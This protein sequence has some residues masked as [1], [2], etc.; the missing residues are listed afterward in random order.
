ME[1]VNQL[2]RHCFTLS[3]Q[4]KVM[5]SKYVKDA[6]H[7]IIDQ[8]DADDIINAATTQGIYDLTLGLLDKERRMMVAGKAHEASA[9]TYREAREGSMEAHNFLSAT[10]ITSIHMRNEKKRDASLAATAKSL[11]KS[12]LSIGATMLKV[13]EDKMKESKEE[14]Y[15][16][17]KQIESNQERVTID[18]IRMLI[19]NANKAMLLETREMDEGMAGNNLNK[20]E[21]SKS[22]ENEFEE[23]E[24]KMRRAGAAL[25]TRMEEV[26]IDLTDTESEEDSHNTPDPLTND[27]EG[28]DYKADNSDAKSHNDKFNMSD[29]DLDVLEVSLGEFKATHSQKYQ[30]PESFLQTLWNKAGPVVRSMKIML[31]LMKTEFKLEVAGL[32]ADSSNVPQTLIDFLLKEAG[33]DPHDAIVLLNQTANQLSQFDEESNA[34]SNKDRDTNTHPPDPGDK[35][36]KASKT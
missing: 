21:S 19:S 5:K 3:Q 23:S 12:V 26:S 16:K 22:K 11:A 9:I 27:K 24:D 2:I 35:H 32:M 31:K 14:E 8:T 33:K 4:Q 17:S 6:G 36:S 10:S 15:S 28:K 34:G 25:I 1:D 7:V 20:K 30:N 29:Y 13:T 18:G